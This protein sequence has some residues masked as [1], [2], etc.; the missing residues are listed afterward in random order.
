VEVRK[1]SARMIPL[2][3]ALLCL[4]AARAGGDTPVPAANQGEGTPFTVLCYHRFVARPETLKKAESQYQLPLSEFKWQ[5]GYLRDNGFNPV[6]LDQLEAYWF[7]G[8]PLPPKP[9]L[10]TF[11]DGFKSIYE[12]AYPVVKEFGYPAVLFL[13]TDFV[14]GQKDSVKYPEIEEMRKNGWAVES[15]TKSHMNLGVEGEKREKLEYRKLVAQ[16][17]SDPLTFIREKFGSKSTALAYPYG[18][19]TE[20]VLKQAKEM[21]YRLAFTVNAG[22]NDLRV[23]RLKLRRNLVLFPINH[24]AFERFFEKKVL[25]LEKFVPGDGD[26]IVNNSPILTVEIE[27][28]ILPKT[29]RFKL[30]GKFMKFTYDPKTRL[31]QHRIVGALHPGGHT[32]T[33]EAKD[34]EG[35]W[36]SYSWYFRVKHRNWEKPGETDGQK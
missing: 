7:D 12:K 2:A 33:L 18:I 3:L 5:M 29:L 8:K 11:D 14:R 27:D 1:K 22:A 17:L 6:S 31:L 19:F 30:G 9:V 4:W 24:K 21:G 34:V 32:V 13:Y 36:R 26:F 10:L 15:H 20:E 16:E 35:N 25:H 23:P 28:E